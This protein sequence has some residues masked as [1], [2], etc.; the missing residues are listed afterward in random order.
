MGVVL[1]GVGVGDC[2]AFGV[3]VPLRGVGEGDCVK[4]GE[5]VGVVVRAAPERCAGDCERLGEM[6]EVEG[7]AMVALVEFV[8][9][10]RLM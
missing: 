3:G 8:E 4:L 5:V 9:F 7:E 2:A 1:R 10:I 6:R